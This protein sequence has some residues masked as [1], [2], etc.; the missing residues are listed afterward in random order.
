M[1]D[2]NQIEQALL[3]LS[4]NARDAMSVASIAFVF[5]ALGLSGYRMGFALPLTEFI[6]FSSIQSCATRG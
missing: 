6:N 5:L 3:N 2:K 1:A 4:V